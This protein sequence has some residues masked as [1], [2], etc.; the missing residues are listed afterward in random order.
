[1][2]DNKDEKVAKI[3]LVVC[4]L[5]TVMVVVSL[6]LMSWSFSKVAVENSYNTAEVL[7]SEVD[8]TDTEVESKRTIKVVPQGGT[9]TDTDNVLDSDGTYGYDTDVWKEFSDLEKMIVRGREMNRTGSAEDCV[10]ATSALLVTNESPYK[11]RVENAQYRVDEKDSWHQITYSFEDGTSLIAMCIPITG[12]PVYWI[13]DKD[14]TQE[15]FDFFDNL[16]LIEKTTN[17]DG[18]Y[19]IVFK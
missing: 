9:S 19:V 2:E 10:L 11:E 14:F 17:A 16:G 12:D 18:K 5:I 3:R 13:Q 8:V 4:I 15:E 7:S 1:M 6:G